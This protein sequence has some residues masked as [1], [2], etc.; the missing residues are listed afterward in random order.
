ML[1]FNT[2]VTQWKKV[3]SHKSLQNYLWNPNPSK[4]ISLKSIHLNSFEQQTIHNMVS[5]LVV[6]KIV[7]Y[8]FQ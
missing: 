1:L 4:T 8:S 3:A 6:H 5:I 2:Q 7:L